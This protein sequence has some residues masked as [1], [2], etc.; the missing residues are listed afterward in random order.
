M[1][2]RTV[3]RILRITIGFIVAFPHLGHAAGLDDSLLPYSVTVNGGA[4]IYL[5]NGLIL[6]VAHVVGGGILEK[7]KVTIA[8]QTLIATVVKES[9]FEQLDLALLQIDEAT[10]PVSLRLRRIP[11]CQGKAW[12]GEEIVSLSAH[13]PVRSQIL[14]PTSLPT[15]TRKFSTVFRDDGTTG[16]SGTAVFEAERKCLIG[17]V[18]RGITQIYSQKGSDKKTTRN[19]AKYFVSVPVIA[20]F[21]P[22]QLRLPAE[23]YPPIQFSFRQ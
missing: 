22:K 9:P 19:I 10:L 17:I 8:N 1:Q 13:G 23:R 6:S 7:P 12:P 3:R 2:V 21:M 15:D 14:A 20:A 4:G 18:S 16:N 5:G 11:L